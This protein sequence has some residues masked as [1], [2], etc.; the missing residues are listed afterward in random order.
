MD[1]W[2]TD[3]KATDLH[4]FKVGGRMLL[5]NIS[6]FIV[7]AAEVKRAS[8]PWGIVFLHRILFVVTQN[9]TGDLKL[10]PSLF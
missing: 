5:P 3:L 2:D 10:C 6:E 8:L 4:S 9:S 7:Q 1:I